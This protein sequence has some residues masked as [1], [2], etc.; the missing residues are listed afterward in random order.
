MLYEAYVYIFAFLIVFLLIVV[1]RLCAYVI[2]LSEWCGQLEK[3]LK[4][5]INKIEIKIE[6]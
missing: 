3:E 6:K 1:Q 4:D 2:K 5:R